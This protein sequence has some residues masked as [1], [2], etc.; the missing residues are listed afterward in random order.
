MLRRRPVAHSGTRLPYRQLRLRRTACLLELQKLVGDA[1]LRALRASNAGFPCLRM[2]QRHR[3]VGSADFPVLSAACHVDRSWSPPLRRSHSLHANAGLI[4]DQQ[5]FA[6]SVQ[7][8]MIRG[9][10]SYAARAPA[11]WALPS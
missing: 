2:P 10:F 7:K 9:N 6:G 5:V 4:G 11:Q 1:R 8:P 3:D